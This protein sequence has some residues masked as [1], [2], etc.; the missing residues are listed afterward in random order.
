M[1]AKKVNFGKKPEALQSVNLEQWVS[2]RESVVPQPPQEQP[3]KMKRLTLD[4]PESLHKA[5][6]RQAVDVG[7][8]MADLL[9]DLLE[10]HYGTKK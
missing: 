4:I 2:D 1:S 5:I 7:V 6:K 9:R 3:E 10:Q 8:T